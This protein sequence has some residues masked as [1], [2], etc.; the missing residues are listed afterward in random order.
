[1]LSF[2]R[3]SRV[4]L[5]LSPPHLPLPRPP[6]ADRAALLARLV[7]LAVHAKAA[8]DP[9]PVVTPEVGHRH[10]ETELSKRL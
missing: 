5:R 3:I 8:L 9:V 10:V 2:M 6:H 7:Q 1:M 4:H